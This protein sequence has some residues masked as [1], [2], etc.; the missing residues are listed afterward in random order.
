M[1]RGEILIQGLTAPRTVGPYVFKPG[2]Y[3]F[4]FEQPGA[5]ESDQKR[6]VV[7]LESTPRSRAQPYQLLVDSGRGSGTKGV[8]VSGK[9]YVHVVRAPGDYVL[10]FTP[11]RR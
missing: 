4:R 8:S 2:G 7:A 9:L 6:L 3:V 10:R 5:R 11:K 1:H